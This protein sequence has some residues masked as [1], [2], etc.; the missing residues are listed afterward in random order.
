MMSNRQ[1]STGKTPLPGASTSLA[2]IDFGEPIPLGRLIVCE[3]SGAWAVAVRSV[4]AEI[5]QLVETRSFAAAFAELC[6]RPASLVLAEATVANLDE[7]VAQL[8]RQSLLFPQ[9]RAVILG[10]G[11]DSEAAWLLRLAGA[12]AVVPRVSDLAKIEPLCRRHFREVPRRQPSL[13]ESLDQPFL[14]E[15]G[16]TNQRQPIT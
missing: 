12:V 10:L 14:P 2:S 4:F 5:F 1:P 9:V 3:R 16:F 6:S 7:L 8:R 15:A 11:D 13:R